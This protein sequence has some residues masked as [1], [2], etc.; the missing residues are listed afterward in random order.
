VH[1]PDKAQGK[2]SASKNEK[3]GESTSNSITGTCLPHSLPSNG[4]PMAVSMNLGLSLSLSLSLSDVL[5]V[6]ATTAAALVL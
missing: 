2:T 3:V 5:P 1:S 6:L 4:L